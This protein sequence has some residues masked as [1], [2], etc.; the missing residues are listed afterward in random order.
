MSPCL[1]SLALSM[2]FAHSSRDLPVFSFRLAII[3]AS[4]SSGRLFMYGRYRFNQYGYHHNGHK[5]SQSHTKDSL[6]SVSAI[7]E[8]AFME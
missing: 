6:E 7:E 8:G 5:E 4:A 1:V 2:I 3:P